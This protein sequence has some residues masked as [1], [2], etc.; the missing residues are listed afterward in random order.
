[1]TKTQ[2]LWVLAG[3]IC[4]SHLA[5]AETITLK[6]GQSVT[7]GIIREFEDRIIVD[8]GYDLLAIPREQ[9]QR[10]T[11]DAKVSEST[12]EIR[13]TEHLYS[14]A[15]LPPSNVK[16]LVDQFGEGVAVI[17]SPSG[18]GSGFFINKQGFLITNFHV[19]ENETRLSVTIFRKVDGEF[20]REKIDEVTIIATNPFL[21]LALL[22]VELPKGYEPV[23]TYLA[24][25]DELRE[26]DT[27]FAI[28]NP[29]GLERSVSEGIISRKNRAEQ[30]LIYIQTTTQI[31]PGNSGGPLFNAS[32]EVI[33]VTNMKIMGGEG[34]GFAIPIRYVI[35]FLRNREAFAYDSTSSE[36][37]YRY[38]QPPQRIKMDVP[39]LLKSG[40]GSD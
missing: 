23:I 7:A 22:K 40:S 9:I 5:A 17:A 3:G 29:L 27:V 19:V 37:G 13:A 34:L 32:G 38:L 24:E 15:D 11:S 26:G 2:W 35:D 21:D 12:G 10:I 4:L 36:A 16:R 6:S 30:G 31:N 18:T 28:G 8:L 25:G 33:G 1:M 14:V 39:E 20:K